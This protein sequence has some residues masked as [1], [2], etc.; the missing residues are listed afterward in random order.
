V[1]DIGPYTTML[2]SQQLRRGLRWRLLVILLFASH[3][4]R[5]VHHSSVNAMWQGCPLGALQS[6]AI[7]CVTTAGACRYIGS[8][9]QCHKYR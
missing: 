2:L 5:A 7:H 6:Q 4:N 3:Y 1:H 9:V 8:P